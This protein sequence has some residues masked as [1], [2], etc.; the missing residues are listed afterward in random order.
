[1]NAELRNRCVSREEGVRYKM[2]GQLLKVERG[3]AK[4][5]HSYSPF[6]L[7]GRTERLEESY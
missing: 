3:G 4:L 7:S 6:G 1:M 5:D 2:V